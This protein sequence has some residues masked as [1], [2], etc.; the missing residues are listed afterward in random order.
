MSAVFIW[1][2]TLLFFGFGFMPLTG[3]IFKNAEDRGWIFSKAMGLFLTAVFFWWL[4]VF[5]IAAFTQRNCLTAAALLLGLNAAG[6][7]LSSRRPDFAGVNVRLLLF[8]EG[9]FSLLFFL[10]VWIIGFRP[11]AYGTEK[12]MDYGFMTSA[13]RSAYMPFADS[14][15]GGTPVN[16]YYGGQ[17]IAAFLTR[18]SGVTA[19]EGYNLMRASVAA[20]SAL[21]PFS[22][23]CQLLFDRFG[24]GF[25]AVSGGI[26]AGLFTAFCG[27]FHYVI[28]GIIKPIAARLRGE[29]YNYWFPDSTRYI[30]YDP[31]LPDKT[32]HEFPAYSTVLG[33]LH[34]HYVNII[35]VL[36]AAAIAYAYM[37]RIARKEGRR[38]RLAFEILSPEILLIGLFTGLFRWTNF[39][40]FPIYFV[41]CGSLVFFINLRHTG[42]DKRA[43]A[44]LMGGQ[45]LTAFLAGCLSSLP[46]T[47]SFDQISSKI[48]LTHSHT[49]PYQF[50]ILWGLPIFIFL[51]YLSLL[52]FERKRFAVPDLAVLLMGLCALGLILM[53]EF[54]YVKDIYTAEH[55]R[56]NTM[57]KLT[58]QAFI[59]FGMVMGY[60]L[61][62]LL[63]TR[64]ALF[65]GLA[66]AGGF[67]LL[68]TSGYTVK[69][70]GAWFGNI[71]DLSLR[72]STDAS[73][74]VSTRFY[75]DYEAVN[76][77]N[78]N[79]EGQP[80]ILEAPGDSYSDYGRISV[81]T[82]LPTVLGWYVHEWLWR[83][84]TAALN[85]RREDIEKIYTSLDE[86][87]VRALLKKYDVSYIYIGTLEREKYPEL[88]GGL[89]LGLGETVWSDG[90]TTF[91][92]KVR[93]APLSG[94]AA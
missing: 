9:A 65:R 81:A 29:T 71:F 34:A 61:V 14:W 11:E 7:V 88:N 18:F 57:F 85:E 41:V 12:F 3:F 5:R 56:A 52:L 67:L 55:Y 86:N 69:A 44:L 50:A 84:D 47:M 32:I 79:V 83:G 80:V 60:T 26:L 45:A 2:S 1:W 25:E 91:I 63:R 13:L 43:F 82:G 93:Q 78:S 92:V 28:Y 35:F 59:L 42:F 74:F 8:E 10:W 94:P 20:F 73:V 19:G 31:D 64:E 66:L 53:P 17:F 38:G 22:L 24:R 21:L 6:L 76:W 77:L 72:V 68:L 51:I 40:D 30:G 90:E 89:L 37:Q 46:F 15:Y 54:I 4:N 36:T 27:S 48:G 62:R 58:Y 70:V 49:L 87:E 75:R 16:Y 33:D 23:V 39:W